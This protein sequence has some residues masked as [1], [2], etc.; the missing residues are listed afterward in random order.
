M[1]DSTSSTVAL[2]L[3]DFKD[4]EDLEIL[5]KNL[6]FPSDGHIFEET[7]PKIC[8]KI[9]LHEHRDDLLSFEAFLIV[10]ICEYTPLKI[11]SGNRWSENVRK[12]DAWLLA[13][14]LLKGYY[15]T[16]ENSIN[17]R[18]N[19]ATRIDEYFKNNAKIYK[20][21]DPQIKKPKQSL[22]KA[23]ERCMKD[24]SRELTKLSQNKKRC[25]EFFQAGAKLP[26]EKEENGK[27]RIK[28][29]E[30]EYSLEKNTFAKNLN[31][32][33][34]DNSNKENKIV[35]NTSQDDNINVRDFDEEKDQES[36][37]VEQE[38]KNN[39]K[40]DKDGICTEG[41]GGS[42][43]SSD[44]KSASASS[45]LNGDDINAEKEKPDIPSEESSEDTTIDKGVEDSETNNSESSPNLSDELY[46]MFFKL[47][48]DNTYFEAIVKKL[49][50][51]PTGIAFSQHRDFC[52]LYMIRIIQ[53]YCKTENDAEFLLAMYG[54]LRKYEEKKCGKIESREI[55]YYKYVHHLRSNKKIDKDN[56]CEAYTEKHKEVLGYLIGKIITELHNENKKL[57]IVSSIVED[58]KNPEVYDVKKGCLHL[59]EPCCHLNPL[60]RIIKWGKR[61]I[62]IILIVATAIVGV[63]LSSYLL[64]LKQTNKVLD[65]P[66]AGGNVQ[67]DA[68][69]GTYKESWGVNLWKGEIFGTKEYS[70]ENDDVDKSIDE[71][72]EEE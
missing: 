58:L 33:K 6:C 8:D 27:E 13:C 67:K 26:R 28:L 30:P 21:L 44:K 15:H 5:I 65:A 9:G 17:V 35:L 37:Q 54:L 29:P 22:E 38:T 51:I 12:R 4:L 14:G 49:D 52:K 50:Y 41:E 66:R 34:I 69:K 1:G 59:P 18:V 70:F 31:V 60:Q 7:S 53:R 43:I 64:F 39:E 3:K 42:D 20:L 23:V 10:I 24:L 36:Q 40:I 47:R 32:L 72:K 68:N 19:N 63:S 45:P 46:D 56:I 48:S 61:N 2:N 57:G 62:K 71:D 16:R 25:L 55:T 11:K